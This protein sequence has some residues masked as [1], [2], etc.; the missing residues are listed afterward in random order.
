MAMSLRLGNRTTV[1]EGAIAAV[2][3]TCASHSGGIDIELLGASGKPPCWCCATT[4]TLGLLLGTP[5]PRARCTP[6]NVTFMGV[7][8][9]TSRGGSASGCGAKR[10]LSPAPSKNSSASSWYCV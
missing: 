7:V 2:A 6:L 5:S 9:A 8:P 10:A 4:A 3:A 1:D